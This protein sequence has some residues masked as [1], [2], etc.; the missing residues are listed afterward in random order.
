MMQSG[1]LLTIKYPHLPLFFHA[2]IGKKFPG[3]LA[4][5]EGT[6]I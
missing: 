1:R 5:S 4:I 3:N 6:L 2:E